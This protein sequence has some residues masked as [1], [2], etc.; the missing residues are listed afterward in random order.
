[1][2]FEY[3]TV[4]AP[5]NVS[6][7]NKRGEEGWEA[8]AMIGDE[9]LLKKSILNG[10]PTGLAKA[11]ANCKHFSTQVAEKDRNAETPGWCGSWKLAMLTTGTCDKFEKVS[12]EGF[13]GEV[14]PLPAG[15]VPDEDSAWHWQ[16]RTE[17]GEKRVEAVTN[18]VAGAAA[19]EHKQRVVVIRS[20]DGKVVRGKTDMV[21]GHDHTI[22][23]VGM[24]EAADGHTHTW[25]IPG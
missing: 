8:C 10:V 19:P 9:V 13:P 11:C 7:L 20:K 5:F 21:N 1:M 2:K 14:H 16:P 3:T 18:Q 25:V 23:F 4:K 12:P 22:N 6:D 17:L 15:A 24:T